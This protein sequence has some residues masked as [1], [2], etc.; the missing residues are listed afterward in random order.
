VGKST[1]LNRL[2]GRK[3]SITSAKPQTTRH[4]ITGIVTTDAYQIVF[5]DTPGFQTRHASA[6]N[7]LMNMSL[8]RSLPSVDVIVWMMEAPKLSDEDLALYHLLPAETPKVVAVNKVDKLRERELL[9][10]LIAE[11]RDR[12]GCETIVPIS[13]RKGSGTKTL[14]CAVAQQLPLAERIYG[15][16]DITVHSERFLAAELMREKLFRMLGDELPYATTVSIASFR[17][18]GG[19]RRVHAD[20]IVDRASQK[21]IVIGAAGEK[22]KRMATRAR[23]DMENLFGGPVFLEVNVKVR[24]GWADSE[25]ALRRM[26]YG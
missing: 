22:L 10:P 13:A 12:T 26:G 23:L 6:L 20:I 19:L 11:I 16:D 1:L 21:P 8:L 3:I 14:E 9:L 5:V 17:T 4:Q 7:R 25:D 2:V 24:S 18:R 15:E